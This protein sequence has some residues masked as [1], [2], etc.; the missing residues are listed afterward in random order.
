M[1]KQVE[2]MGE[3]GE[4]PFSFRK[5]IHLYKKYHQD[6]R[7]SFA[8]VKEQVLTSHVA[9]LKG[10]Q[11]N[12]AVRHVVGLA[13]LPLR[14]ASRALALPRQTIQTA[15]TLCDNLF[16]TLVD[17][18]PEAL[19]NQASALQGFVQSILSSVFPPSSRESIGVEANDSEEIHDISSPVAPPVAES[20]TA[21]QIDD[22]VEKEEEVGAKS[23]RS[24]A[25]AI[26]SGVTYRGEEDTTIPVEG[27]SEEELKA[28]EEK[29]EEEE[30]ENVDTIS[31][32][33]ATPEPMIGSMK[34]IK[35]L[36][37]EKKMSSPLSDPPPPTPYTA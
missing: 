29:E 28:A 13:T 25:D 18:L 17:K 1:C 36:K 16:D 27:S 23:F 21:T 22:E 34:S 19:A 14:V 7:E 30:E 24:Y 31:P 2:E 37:S 12:W 5:S 4:R 20:D 26:K 9:L 11:D 32:V 8:E 3:G 35:S 10:V 33:L 6:Y 15:K